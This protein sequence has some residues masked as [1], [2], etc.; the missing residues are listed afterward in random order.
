MPPS[1]SDYTQ[2]YCICRHAAADGVCMR[3][4]CQYNHTLLDPARIVALVGEPPSSPAGSGA[5][6]EKEKVCFLIEYTKHSAILD[7]ADP[8]ELKW[9]MRLLAGGRA[10]LC[11]AGLGA[12]PLSGSVSVQPTYP[13]KGQGREAV[14]TMDAVE[15]RVFGRSYPVSIAHPHTAC[16][17]LMHIQPS[18][19]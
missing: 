13:K 17:R 15:R 4:C 10:T 16:R 1:G 18:P 3:T 14:A 7:G 9:R 5:A 6:D 8:D 12:D 2:K 11:E 19:A